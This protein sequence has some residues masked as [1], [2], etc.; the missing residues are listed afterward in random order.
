MLVNKAQGYDC[1]E[2]FP[3]VR[4]Y[5]TETVLVVVGI[6][7][8]NHRKIMLS[9]LNIFFTYSV[10]NDYKSNFVQGIQK[11]LLRLLDGILS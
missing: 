11:I 5:E 10:D 4:K 9:V 2:R 6:G 8:I 7:E 3:S 1:C